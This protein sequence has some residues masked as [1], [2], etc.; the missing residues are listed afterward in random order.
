MQAS[1]DQKEG[2]QFSG[3]KKSLLI[4]GPKGVGKHSLFKSIC[5]DL[6][7][8]I[9]DLSASKLTGEKFA[10]KDEL[11][12]L[13]HLVSKVSHLLKPCI[14]FIDQ[15]DLMFRKKA[16]KYED[17]ILIN[18]LFLKVN[19]KKLYSSQFLGRKL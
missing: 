10:E 2:K 19:F 17:V 6:G 4:T 13:T 3:F 12:M 1:D 14:I 15:S 8:F 5:K 11:K 9:I 18:N 7:A 16:P